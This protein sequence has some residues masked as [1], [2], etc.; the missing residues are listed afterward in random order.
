VLVL[1]VGDDLFSGLTVRQGEVAGIQRVLLE[2]FEF[3]QLAL[4]VRKPTGILE[5][6]LASDV[7]HLVNDFG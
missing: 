5:L 6:F 7:L 2:L 3:L 1:K 4:D